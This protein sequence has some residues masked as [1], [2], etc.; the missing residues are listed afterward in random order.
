M[1]SSN[2]KKMLKQLEVKPAKHKKFIKH[3]QPKERSCGVTKFR[4]RRCGNDGAHIKK[5]GLHLCRHCFR[6]M[7]ESLGFKKFD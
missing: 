1:T 5:Y 6:E 7:A 4:C 3:N 2:H